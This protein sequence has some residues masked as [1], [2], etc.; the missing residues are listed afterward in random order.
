[1]RNE[2]VDDGDLVGGVGVDDDDDKQ[3]I[4]GQGE[5]NLDKEVFLSNRWACACVN[6]Q[7][8]L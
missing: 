4:T 7:K 3:G 8:K 1:L 5:L 2:G 6:P